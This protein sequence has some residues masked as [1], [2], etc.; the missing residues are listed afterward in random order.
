[1]I[2]QFLYSISVLEVEGVQLEINEL[3][4]YN[5]SQNEIDNIPW[6]TKKTFADFLHVA[7]LTQLDLNKSQWCEVVEYF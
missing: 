3:L 1:M 7:L 2:S 4:K 5:F 6:Q